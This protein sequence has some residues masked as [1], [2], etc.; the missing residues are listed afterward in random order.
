MRYI[1]LLSFCALVLFVPSIVGA[2]ST[3]EVVMTAEVEVTT[4]TSDVAVTTEAEADLSYDGILVEEAEDVPSRF[5]L[6]WRGI[7]ERVRLATTFDLVAKAELAI[8]YAEERQ[9]I[10]ER[11][12]TES[13]DDAAV[14]RAERVLDRSTRL[15]ERVTNR[16]GD[17]ATR[18][19]ERGERLLENIATFEARRTERLAEME[20]RIIERVEDPERA[21]RLL[22]RIDAE[23]ERVAQR[24]HRLSEVLEG[25]A[26]SAEAEARLEARAAR[27]RTVV[28]STADV[29]MQRQELMNALRSGDTNAR[30]ALQE[31]HQ[32][33]REAVRRAVSNTPELM[34]VRDR[35]EDRMD[36]REDARDVR[37]DV[38]DEAVNGGR[39]DSIEDRRD[40]REDVRD[41]REDRREAL[42]D[43]AAPSP[44]SATRNRVPA[45][46]TGDSGS[47]SEQ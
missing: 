29:Q 17:I 31:L 1:F 33:R 46:E 2:T 41:V 8:K 18:T 16:M 43:A 4:T 35:V 30:E 14:A 10:A 45:E 26:L 9:A 42:R 27:I 15:I 7:A 21:E 5:G 23:R 19:D 39:L 24:T 37:E 12:L 25:A 13:D 34:R 3:V 36:R 44:R 20:S 11:I 32:E 38:R 47:P 6:F 22:N 40:V 28:S